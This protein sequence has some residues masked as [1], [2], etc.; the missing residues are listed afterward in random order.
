VQLNH[1]ALITGH[2]RLT[3]LC[4]VADDVV[5]VLRPIV[6]HGGDLPGGLGLRLLLSTEKRTGGWLYTIKQRNVPLVTCGL[7]ITQPAADELW[8]HLLDVAKVVRLPVS[9]KQPPIPWLSV[10]I[11]PG[12]ARAG[13]KIADLF[14]DLERCV[15]WTLIDATGDRFK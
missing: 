6:A 15:A 12:I 8:P 13:R 11:L 4:E 7:A 1:Y 14:G 10:A 3:D 9:V 2:G 5:E